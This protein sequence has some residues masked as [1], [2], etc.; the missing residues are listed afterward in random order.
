MTDDVSHS[1]DITPSLRKDEIN[2]VVVSTTKQ[3]VLYMAFEIGST[4]FKL[5]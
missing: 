5:T 3:E 1:M 4:F 2:S